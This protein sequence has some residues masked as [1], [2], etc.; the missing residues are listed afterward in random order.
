VNTGF[1]ETM[2]V[3]RVPSQRSSCTASGTRTTGWDPCIKQI[4]RS[5]SM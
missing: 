5:S 2:E 4:C 3:T 1:C